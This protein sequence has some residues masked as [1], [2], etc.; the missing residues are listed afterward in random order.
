MLAKAS[1]G[2]ILF[3]YPL[4]DK[5]CQKMGDVQTFEIVETYLRDF[6][7]LRIVASED[8]NRKV[9]GYVCY[10]VA[11]DGMTLKLFVYHMYAETKEAKNELWNY[12]QEQAKFYKCKAIQ[13]VTTWKDPE[14]LCKLYEGR[15]KIIG[16]VLE[17]PV[18]EEGTDTK[19]RLVGG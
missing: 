9:N 16:Y 19:L 4:I 1:R 8:E 3:L 7:N 17:V 13:G 10:G 6:D 2:S 18:E 11:P 5:Y 12:V 14:K 15:P